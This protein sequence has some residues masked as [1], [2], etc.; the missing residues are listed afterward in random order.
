MKC[1]AQAAVL[2]AGL[3]AAGA[4]PGAPAPK[5]EASLQGT[6]NKVKAEYDGAAAAAGEAAR[7]HVTAA[8][9]TYTFDGGWIFGENASAEFTYK[10]NPT[11]APKSIDLI[12]KDGKGTE[13]V[14]PGIYELRGGRLKV[15]LG[16]KRPTTFT[17]PKGSERV[18]IVFQRE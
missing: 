13:T 10:V 12:S 18:L 16:K 15:C 9:V 14:L 5:A 1:G 3:L 7:V 17:A 6:W 2:L 11:K 4:A 8:K